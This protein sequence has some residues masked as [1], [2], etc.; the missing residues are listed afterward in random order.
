M[1]LLKQKRAQLEELESKLYQELRI[2]SATRLPDADSEAQC[3]HLLDNYLSVHKDNNDSPQKIRKSET[4]TIMP[5]DPSEE[6]KCVNKY[7]QEPVRAEF[8]I[9]IGEFDVPTHE[10]INDY[11]QSFY[12]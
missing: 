4:K 5:S 3:F 12:K 6:V 10:F 9:H 2:F 11:M 8:S 7:L 1:Q